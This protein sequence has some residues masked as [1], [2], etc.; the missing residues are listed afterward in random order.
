MPS[1]SRYTGS[2]ARNQVKAVVGP[3]GVQVAI[4]QGDVH[5][6]LLRRSGDDAGGAQ[7]G[8]LGGV[9]AELVGEHLVGVLAEPRQARSRALRPRRSS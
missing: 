1:G 3:G 2:L 5:R 7:P 4:E 9:E 6:C 8:D